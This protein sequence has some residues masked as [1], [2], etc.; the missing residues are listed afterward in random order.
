M[1]K[2][3]TYSSLSLKKNRRGFKKYFCSF[4]V[5]INMV[6]ANRAMIT[7]GMA[8]TAG[9]DLSSLTHGHRPSQPPHSL[10]PVSFWGEWGV[11]QH[12]NRRGTIYD[13]AKITSN[14][15][16]W[17]KTIQHIISHNGQF[18]A[19]PPALNQIHPSCPTAPTSKP[20]SRPQQLFV[21]SIPRGQIA[22]RGGLIQK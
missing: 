8:T 11:L 18:F 22:L 19:A 4:Y 7:M 17:A 13:C 21:V 10:H 12:E 16:S 1:A 6:Q 14:T 3:I 15:I 5:G 20:T 2:T 9:I